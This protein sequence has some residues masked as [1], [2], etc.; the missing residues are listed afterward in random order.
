MYFCVIALIAPDGGVIVID[1][2][3]QL[4]L[5]MHSYRIV[6]YMITIAESLQ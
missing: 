5:E 3:T 6:T 2:H 4:N 1:L